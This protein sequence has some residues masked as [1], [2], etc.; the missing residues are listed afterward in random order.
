MMLMIRWRNSVSLTTM[1]GTR[2]RLT[3]AAIGERVG[4]LVAWVSRVPLDPQ[5]GHLMARGGSL[6]PLPKVGVFHWLL[7]RGPPAIALPFR[8]PRG[9]S[10]AQVDTIGMQ[11]HRCRPAQALERLNRGHQLHAV[12]SR[13]RLAAA[14]LLG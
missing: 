10:A 4:A 8:Q 9:D 11:P 7:I 12:V 5:P 14:D 6:E 13:T 1:S 2:G 3:Q